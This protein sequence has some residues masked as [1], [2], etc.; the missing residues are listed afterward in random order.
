MWLLW[1]LIVGM[2][3]KFIGGG[4]FWEVVF[5]W[6]WNVWDGIVCC[7][8]CGGWLLWRMDCWSCWWLMCSC[9][10][11]LCSCV[12]NMFVCLWLVCLVV[13]VCVLML[14]CF[15]LCVVCVG[16]VFCGSDVLRC[17]LCW[18]S[19]YC[20]FLNVCIVIVCLG[21]YLVLVGL[22]IVLVWLD[23]VCV[24]VL[25]WDWLYLCWVGL[26]CWCCGWCLDWWWVLFLCWGVV[27]YSVLSWCL[28]CLYWLVLWL[29]ECFFGIG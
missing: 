9:L 26:F 8:N 28:C 15:S 14:V 16:L 12:W 5:L 20:F 25:C 29:L 22:V 3:L 18:D 4:N 13:D 21:I 11:V 23:L 17:W 6:L 10:L 7:G 27:V 19:W 1:R 24:V 2:I